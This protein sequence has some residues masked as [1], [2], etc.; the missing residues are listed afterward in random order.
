MLY[1]YIQIFSV[2]IFSCD[3]QRSHPMT[4]SGTYFGSVSKQH[5]HNSWTTHLVQERGSKDIKKERKDGGEEGRRKSDIEP[6]C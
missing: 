3:P 2:A 4:V 1:E 6:G 5:H